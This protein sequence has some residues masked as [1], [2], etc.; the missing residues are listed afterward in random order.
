MS[1][2]VK[3][4]RDNYLKQIIYKQYFFFSKFK[5]C[6][7]QKL[8]KKIQ[9]YFGICQYLLKKDENHIRKNRKTKKKKKSLRIKGLN[10][11]KFESLE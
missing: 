11:N 9:F 1:L 4:A 8:L 5:N 6:Q 2:V 3:D 10:H 7:L